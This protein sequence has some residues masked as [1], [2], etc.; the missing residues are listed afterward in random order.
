MRGDMKRN[1]MAS[2]LDE[3]VSFLRT[4]KLCDLLDWL[5]SEVEKNTNQCAKKMWHRFHAHLQSQKN[6]H[7]T[8]PFPQISVLREVRVPL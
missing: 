3:C 4:T 8:W 2:E 6:K 5:S 7:S 1:Y